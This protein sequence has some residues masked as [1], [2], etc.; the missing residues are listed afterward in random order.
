MAAD[1]D[2]PAV[3]NGEAL[4]VEARSVVVLQQVF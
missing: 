3:K 1:V 4:S 2:P